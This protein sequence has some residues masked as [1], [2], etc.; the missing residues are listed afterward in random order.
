[1]RLR[2]LAVDDT[3][4]LL[5]L[6]DVVG[7]PADS[8][9]AGERIRRL[10]GHPDYEAWVVEDHGALLGFATGQLNW[11][12]Q[13]SEPVAELTG[14]AVLEEAQGHGVGTSLLDAFEAWATDAGALRL[15]ITS[16]SHRDEAH[17]FYQ[18]RGY[19]VSGI[20]LHRGQSHG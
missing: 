15:K 6:L 16:G 12:L 10:A 4:G 20:R 14:L 11:M 5:P 2:K 19:A 13:V 9:E 8:T 17:T 3:L 1:M 7:W 18:R